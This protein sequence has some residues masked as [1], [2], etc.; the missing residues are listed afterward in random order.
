ME[1]AEQVVV[2]LSRGAS[3]FSFGDAVQSGSSD[4]RYVPPDEA[5]IEQFWQTFPTHPRA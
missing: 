1:I 3:N 5:A 2:L 4:N